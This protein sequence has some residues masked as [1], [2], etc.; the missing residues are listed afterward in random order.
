[1][2]LQRLLPALAVAAT[3]GNA[4]AVDLVTVYRDA[5]VS[6]PVYQAN[7]AIYMA[8]IERLPQARAGYRPF[9]AGTASIFRNHVEF[10]GAPAQDYTTKT[11]AI[12]L[13]Q[14]IFRLQNWIAIGQAR[15]QV[16]QAEAV[17]AN[18]QQDLGIRVA[19]AYFDVLLAQD[20]VALSETQKTAIDQQLAQAKRNFEVGT[21][22]IVDTLEAQARY[23]QS[24]AKEIADRNDLEVK[25]RALQVLL[26]KLPESLSALR[27]PLELAPP[28]PNDIEAWVRAA[29]ESSFQ[30]AFSRENFA[31]MQEEVA[32]Q[33]AGHLPTLDLSG[34]YSRND[35]PT[36]TIAG[37]IGPV[38]NTSSIGLVL[39]VP[40]YS[41]GIVQSRVREALA[42]RERAEQDLESTRRNVAQAVR[43]NFLNVTSGIAQ[44]RA[45]EQALT[46]TRSQLDSTILG[47]DV[48]VRTS[49]DVLNAQQQV[50]QTRR[51]LQQARYNFLLSTLRL[52]AAAGA[53]GEADIEAVNRTLARG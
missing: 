41:G 17:L 30:I 21:A 12:T 34:S 11:Y 33:R 18:A 19:Q 49:V 52:K 2:R 50:F 38:V 22:T 6:D 5:Q 23:D 7:R 20:N 8:T 37:I 45:L 29:D 26:G 35:S 42:N 16:V 9:I 46:S 40:I 1:M 13:S 4:G 28:Q 36:N 43:T 31:F 10:Q 44:V 53:L 14:P 27:E 3:I 25:R 48:G 32:R 47:R 39:S 51:D 24:N 15:H